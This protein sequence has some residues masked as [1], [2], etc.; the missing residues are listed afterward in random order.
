MEEDG[1]ANYSRLAPPQN[2]SSDPLSLYE[3][4]L[5]HRSNSSSQLFP[6]EYDALVNMSRLAQEDGA[7]GGGSGGGGGVF[8]N[9]I[10]GPVMLTVGT[11]GILSNLLCLAVL[12]RR[13]ELKL[14]HDYLFLLR[15]QSVFDLL[16]LVTST[17]ITA[18][19][20]VFPG[21]KDHFEPFVLPWIFPL[22]QI[23]MTASIYTT[24]LLSFERYFSIKGD[25]NKVKAFPA[26]ATVCAILVF[27]VAINITRFFELRAVAREDMTLEK[28]NSTGHILTDFLIRHT[29]VYSVRPTERFYTLAYFLGYNMIGSFLVSL[30]IPVVTLGTMNTLIWKRLKQVWKN[31]RRMR[32][33]ERRN[34]RAALSLLAIV[35]LFFVC[36]SMKLV[37]SGY[38]VRWLRI[39]LRTRPR[40]ARIFWQQED[41]FPNKG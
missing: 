19:P 40:R 3:T 15:A 28:V 38:Q 23:S 6:P 24:I 34:T 8:S 29:V 7:N 16:Y 37:V 13:K 26:M 33:K 36:H 11:I 21:V 18:I 5:V 12:H 27:S 2:V 9:P 14:N 32:V 31:R 22:M 17:P 30:F 10:E 25:M 20:Y 39:S 4:D 35:I 41:I 1:G